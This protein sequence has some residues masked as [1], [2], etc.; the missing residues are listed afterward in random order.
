MTD[1]IGLAKLASHQQSFDLGTVLVKILDQL[2]T[3][4]VDT[5][6]QTIRLLLVEQH[7]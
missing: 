6:Q 5:D 4:A 1:E 2:Q 3:R 7:M